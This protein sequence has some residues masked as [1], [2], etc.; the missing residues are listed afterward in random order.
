VGGGGVAHAGDDLVA[1]GEA[2]ASGGGDIGLAE[3]ACL[4][5]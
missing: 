4:A 3:L 5:A 2:A 1:D